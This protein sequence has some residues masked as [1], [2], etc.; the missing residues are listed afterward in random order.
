ML[1]ILR[2]RMQTSPFIPFVSLSVLLKV[3][4]NVSRSWLLLW[5]LELVHH[6]WLTMIKLMAQ[7]FSFIRWD[8]SQRLI[9]A[10]FDLLRDKLILC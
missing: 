4:Q 9:E 5:Q 8:A 2:V 7:F 10:V 1:T 3:V 6:M